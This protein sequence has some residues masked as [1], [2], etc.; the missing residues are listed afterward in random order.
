MTVHCPK[1]EVYQHTLLA[2]EQAPGLPY[3][4]PSQAYPPGAVVRFNG[5]VWRAQQWNINR[6]PNYEEQVLWCV[7]GKS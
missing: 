7:H 4:Q 2:T 3:W 1:P 5:Q 6:S